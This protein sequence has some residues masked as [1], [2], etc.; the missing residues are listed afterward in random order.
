MSVDAI[1][2]GV[3]V[4]AGE[5]DARAEP[6]S[7]DTW[8]DA[9]DIRMPG[10]RSSSPT[11]SG[12]TTKATPRCHPGGRKAQTLAGFGNPVFVFLLAIVL[13]GGVALSEES[14]VRVDQPPASSSVTVQ[15][16]SPAV[17]LGGCSCDDG[18]VCTEDSCDS[19]GAC[20]H[21]PLDCDDG[22]FCTTD[23][24][25]ETAGCIHSY[26]ACNDNNACTYDYCDESYGCSYVPVNISD[27][28]VCTIDICDPLTGARF[29][30]IDCSDTSAC[31]ADGCDPITGCTHAGI[32]EGAPCGDPCIPDGICAQGVCLGTAVNCDDGNGCT[33]DS[34]ASP[35]GQAECVH[36]NDRNTGCDDGNV[37]T[38]HDICW[39]GSCAG[40]VATYRQGIGS[41]IGVGEHPVFNAIGNFNHDPLPDIVVVNHYSHNVTILLNNGTGGFFASLGS[42]IGSGIYP[43]TV[44]VADFDRDGNSDLAVTAQF[45]Q[46]TILLGDGQGGFVEAPGS[47]LDLGRPLF[48]ATGDFNRDGNADLAVTIFDPAKVAILLGDGAGGFTPT[49]GSPMNAGTG[50]Y[51]LLVGDFNADAKP[52]IAV[53]NSTPPTGAGGVTLLLGNGLGGFA[54]STGSPF[55]VGRYPV[56]MATGDFDLDGTRDLAVGSGTSSIVS[57]LL[58]DGSGGFSEA[59]DSPVSVPYPRSVAALDFD[60]D[61]ALDL[62]VANS[63]V[64]GDVMILRGDGTGRF[65]EAAGSPAPVEAQPNCIAVGDFDLDGRPDMALTN[66]GSG[67]VSILFNTANVSPAGTACS[68]SNICTTNDTCLNGLCVGGSDGSCD[69]DNPCTDDSCSLP[70][71]CAHTPNTAACSDGNACTM[72][73]ACSGGACIGGAAVSCDDGNICTDDSCDTSLGCVHACNNDCNVKGDGYWKKLCKDRDHDDHADDHSETYTSRDVECVSASCTFSG[74]ET[75]EGICDVLDPPHGHEDRCSKAERKFLALLLNLCRCRLQPSQSIDTHCEPRAQTV[76]EAVAHADAALCNPDRSEEDC[77]HPECSAEEI[78]NGSALWQNTL[79]LTREDHDIRLTW[80]AVYGDPVAEA[81]RKYRIWRRP[82][83]AGA[84]VMIGEVSDHTFTFVDTQAGAG[85]FEYEVTATY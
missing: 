48:V 12:S 33:S 75:I 84:Y 67:N 55:G 5:T 26:N 19:T 46:V 40:G 77:R 16:L 82:R 69:D 61:G 25:Y 54:A 37:C 62:A 29:F 27:G 44:A 63:F 17:L 30:P 43:E 79:R 78:T 6:A 59:P 3:D 49:P 15:A 85:S 64:P 36:A 20:V 39:N 74:V 1:G 71:G 8:F 35:A 7:S 70:G 51:F 22:Y 10:G 23:L 32:N 21:T 4:E 41:P 38:T 73:D 76:A 42:P 2:L 24:C 65:V 58:G 66:Y 9:S 57:I 50:P 83:G 45:N 53:S 28:N 18:L 13:S 60:L 81:S 14:F 52:D 31:T 68:D 72:N 56:S 11:G 34:C 47:P 80:S